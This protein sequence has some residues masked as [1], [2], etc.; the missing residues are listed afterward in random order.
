LLSTLTVKRT[1]ILTGYLIRFTQQSVS[2]WSRDP[3]FVRHSPNSSTRR[4]PQIQ[5]IWPIR[6]TNPSKRAT[7]SARPWLPKSASEPGP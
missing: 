4:V 2:P 3:A 6:P 5:L 1:R 7:V